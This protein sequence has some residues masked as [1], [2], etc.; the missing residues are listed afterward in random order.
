MKFLFFL[1]EPFRTNHDLHETFR[2]YV[3]KLLS[4]SEH[5]V[6]VAGINLAI[7]MM[8]TSTAY[9]CIKTL[10]F[11]DLPSNAAGASSSAHLWV[12]CGNLR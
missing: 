3:P 6:I 4:S 5:S 1:Q 11:Q 12:F 2:K 9:Q 7:G 8:K 10:Q